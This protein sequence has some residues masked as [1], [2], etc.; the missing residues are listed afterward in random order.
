MTLTASAGIAATTTDGGV[1]LELPG[2]AVPLGEPISPRIA[3]LYRGLLGVDLS[4]LVVHRE[5]PVVDAP[6]FVSNRD[7]FFAPGVYG[8][9]APQTLAVL[10]AAVLAAIAGIDGPVLDG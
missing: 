9:D 2:D 10:D 4:S 8:V 6:A 5:A 3:E 1:T 7:L